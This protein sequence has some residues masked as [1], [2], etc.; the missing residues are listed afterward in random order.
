MKFQ[1]TKLRE[2]F[3]EVFVARWKR[4]ILVEAR[5]QFT[6]S[7]KKPREEKIT[8]NSHARGSKESHSESRKYVKEDDIRRSIS[9]KKYDKEVVEI[10]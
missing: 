10:T 9:E 2:G 5:V 7:L 8:I 1:K 3:G 4:L 6:K